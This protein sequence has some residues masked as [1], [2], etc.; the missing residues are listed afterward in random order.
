M[1]KG[2]ILGTAALLVAA[3]SAVAAPKHYGDRGYS[4]RGN[5]TGWERVQIARSAARVAMVKRQAY[6]DGRVTRWE[7]AQIRQAE[8]RH[9]ALVRRAHRS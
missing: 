5:V 6:R 1:M 2:L 9:A 7:R 3:G 8:A 4:S